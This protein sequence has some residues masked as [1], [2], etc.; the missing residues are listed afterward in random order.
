M[1]TNQTT[2]DSGDQKSEPTVAEIVGD[3]RVPPLKGKMLKTWVELPDHSWLKVRIS[4]P[5]T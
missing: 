5:V 4:R 2:L 3:L 1:T